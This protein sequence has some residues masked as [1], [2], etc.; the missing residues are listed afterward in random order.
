WRSLP[1]ARSTWSTMPAR[2]PFVAGRDTRGWRVTPRAPQKWKW[3]RATPSTRA[4]LSFAPTRCPTSG[5]TTTK[6]QWTFTFTF[7]PASPTTRPTSNKPRVA[8][9]IPVPAG[10]SVSAT[11]ATAPITVE[12]LTGDV[13][14]SSDT[15]QIVVR[16]VLRAHVHVRGVTAPVS[17]TDIINGHV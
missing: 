13:I 17:L 2:L 5:P 14:L 10:I 9:N 6:P 3:I 7:P 11:T 12:G 1:A 8:F 16:N 15:G 4:R